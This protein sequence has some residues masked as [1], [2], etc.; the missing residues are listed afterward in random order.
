[1]QPYKIIYETAAILHPEDD[2][3]QILP[4]ATSNKVLLA[5]DNAWYLLNMSRRIFRAGLKH[6]M[7]DAKW[8]AFEEVFYGFDPERVRLMSDDDL[9]K[10]MQDKRIIRHWRKINAV[11]SNAT[12]MYEQGENTKSFGK[13]LTS[14]PVSDTA[15]LWHY[16]KKNFT[17]MGGRSAPYF[18]RMVGKDTFILTNDVIRAL[19]RWGAFQGIPSY[20]KAKKE[21]QGIF[22]IWAEESGRPL[23]QLSR[24]LALSVNE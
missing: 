8:S 15:D 6:S 16:L 4:V 12:I 20:E 23:C 5:R 3:E 21:V 13:F 2:I 10:L 18:L 1:M 7:V 9:D 17:Q 22:N 14:W 11:R 19:N 24:I